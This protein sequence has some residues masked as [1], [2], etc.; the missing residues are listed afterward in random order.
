MK[1]KRVNQ[2]TPTGDAVALYERLSY[3]GSTWFDLMTAPANGTGSGFGGG[4][5]ALNNKLDKMNRAY[6]TDQEA[7]QQ[8]ISQPPKE[9]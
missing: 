7:T 4:V 5:D 9:K 2:P 3:S 8:A 1:R 6:Q